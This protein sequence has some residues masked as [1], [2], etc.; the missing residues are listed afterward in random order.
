M[1]ARIVLMVVVKRKMMAAMAV[2]WG[3]EVVAAV[4]VAIE[5]TKLVMKWW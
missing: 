5:A 3:R 4:M 1:V 2:G